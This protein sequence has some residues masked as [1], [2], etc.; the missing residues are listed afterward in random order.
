MSKV[1]CLHKQ[2]QRSLKNKNKCKEMLYTLSGWEEKTLHIPADTCRIPPFPHSH[3]KAASTHLPFN[4]TLNQGGPADVSS[5]TT[6]MRACTASRIPHH[7]GTRFCN[8]FCST[9]SLEIKA[10]CVNVTLLQPG[11]FSS[12]LQPSFFWS[13]LTSRTQLPA[14]VHWTLE[15]DVEGIFHSPR[16]REQN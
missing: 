12:S 14:A 7:H 6:N 2:M 4:L 5:E 13:K 10:S 11:S 1:F 9:S 16:A 15:G 8:P 3:I